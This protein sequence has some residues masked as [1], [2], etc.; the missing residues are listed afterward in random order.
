MATQNNASPN[1]KNP[2]NFVRNGEPVGKLEGFSAPLVAEEGLRWLRERRDRRDR[3]KPFLLSVWTHEP[4]MPI[5]SS[6]EFMKPY[7]DIDDEGI[8]QHHGNITQLDHAFGMLMKG[9]DE[10]GLRENT[11]V[12]FTSDNGPE[13]KGTSGRTR[14]STGGL[15]GRKRDDHEGGIRVAGLVRWPGHIEPGTVSKVPVIGSDIFT[16]ALGVAGIEVPKDRTIDGADL[17]P[18]FRGEAVERKVPLFWRTHIAPEKSHAAMRIG[19]WKIVADRTLTEFQL[20]EI[21]KDWKEEHDLA[22]EKPEKLAEMKA[23]FME[24]WRG[25]ET[26]GPREWWENEKLREKAPKR[27]KAKQVGDG[28]DE[29][30]NWPIVRGG[31]VSKSAFGYRLTSEGEAFAVRPLEEP[32]T[33]KD[34]AVFKL[35]YQSATSSATRNAMFCFGQQASNDALIKVGTAIGKGSHEIF[36]GGWANASSGGSAKDAFEPGKKFTAHVIVDL[37]KRVAVLEVGKARIEYPL[38]DTLQEVKFI[39][40]YTK[41][42]ASDFSVIEIAE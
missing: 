25:I 1:H 22:A 24:V 38:P 39:G 37:G 20:Y 36:Q 35:D 23:K 32:L 3:E 18:A 19:D 14:G 28:K 33:G 27:T 4:H 13:G 21:E 7:A 40:I 31:T 5:E 15:R 34:R 12:F 16:T 10:L 8:R 42:T 41:A 29:T 2:T 30:G 9:L 11:I 17:R 26:E 6:E